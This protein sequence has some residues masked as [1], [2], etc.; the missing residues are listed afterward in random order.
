MSRTQTS[1]SR[2]D[3]I[4][5]FIDTEFAETG[6][7]L[8]PT[9]DLI[10]IAIVCEDGREYYAESKEFNTDH[11]NDW[12]RAHV[13]PKLGP[14]LSREGRDTIAKDIIS[15]IEADRTDELPEFWG[16]YCDYDW[17]VFCWL[18]GNMADLP[19]CFPM[20][21]MDLEQWYRQLGCP[22][23]KPPQPRDEH[24]AMA[25]ARWNR[26]LWHA[27][28]HWAYSAGLVRR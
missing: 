26:E 27:L 5:Y 22:D 1:R 6:G 23:V 13:L 10:S 2:R 24:N 19:E 28:N 16:Y 18:Y 4:K 15:F 8:T 17:V 7:D 14:P 25:D 21:C 3:A 20:L 9:I 12:V 11:C